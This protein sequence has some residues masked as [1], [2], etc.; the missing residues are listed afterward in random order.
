VAV[1]RWMQP[2]VRPLMW[3]MSWWLTGGEPL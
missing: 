2:A 1:R 3:R